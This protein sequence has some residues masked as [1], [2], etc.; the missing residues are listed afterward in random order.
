MTVRSAQAQWRNTLKEGDGTLKTESE[1]VDAPYHFGSRF[2]DEPG[3]NPEELIAAAHA[4]CFSM[5]FANQLAQAGHVAEEVRTR[6][7]VHLEKDGDGMSI[8]RSEL[9][10]RAKVPGIDEARFQE[11]AEAAKEGCIISRALGAVDISL[12]AELVS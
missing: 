4:G 2:A 11:I 9:I 8:T 5:A 3:T 1:V 6:A 12:E 10:T 7:R